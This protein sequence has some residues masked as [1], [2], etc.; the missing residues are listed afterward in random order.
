MVAS[1][2]SKSI[3][4]IEIIAPQGEVTIH[5]LCLGDSAIL[6]AVA[7]SFNRAGRLLGRYVERDGLITIPGRSVGS[8]HL[9]AGSGSFCLAQVCI[10]TGLDLA[11]RTRREEL[12]RHIETETAR[13]YADGEVLPPWSTLRLKIVTTVETQKLSNELPETF[14]GTRTLTQY[15]YFRTQGPPGLATLST[16]IGATSPMVYNKGKAT[17]TNGS[18]TVDGTDVE[19]T[20]VLVGAEFHVDQDATL[21]RIVSVQED[22]APTDAGSSI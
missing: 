13:W 19:W 16:P 11:Q 22:P 10:K 21:Y 7:E 8:V 12:A 14:S 1:E 20:S 2:H 5:T 9:S 15:A 6:P 18:A 4:R 17:V 3:A